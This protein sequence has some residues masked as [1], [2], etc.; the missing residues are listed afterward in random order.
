VVAAPVNITVLYFGAWI[1]LLIVAAYLGM[2]L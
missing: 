1:V 2:H